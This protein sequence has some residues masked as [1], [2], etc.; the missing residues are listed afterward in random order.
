MKRAR[1]CSALAVAC[2]AGLFVGIG[3]AQEGGMPAWMRPAPEHKALERLVGNWEVDSV[4][5]MGP[6]GTEPMKSK[7]KAVGKSILGG[8]FVDQEYESEMMGQPFKG[9]LTVGFDTVAKE[10]VSCWV[11]SM[12]P[13]MYVSR[14]KEKEG[15]IVYEGREPSHMTGE[16]VSY[17]HVV[18]WKSDDEYTFEMIGAGPDGK[19]APMGTLTYRRVK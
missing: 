19:M 9:R 11:D 18:T 15:K 10:Y 16:M 13:Y 17:Q 2:A 12:S 4:F 3:V 7:G 5:H 8:H 6:P 1:F 14:G